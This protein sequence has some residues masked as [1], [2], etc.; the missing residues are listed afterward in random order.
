[1]RSQGNSVVGATQTPE[2]RATP[3]Q[4]QALATLWRHGEMRQV[5][6]VRGTLQ[7]PPTVSRMLTRMERNA[8]IERAHADDDA[9]SSSVRLTAEGSRLRAVLPQKLLRHFRGYL[10]RF[11]E[12]EQRQ[13]LALLR[14]LRAISIGT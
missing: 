14:E 7:D 12:A 13:L 11:S 1:L 8:W 9:R 3:E 5:D 2:G 4:W 6:I 10:A